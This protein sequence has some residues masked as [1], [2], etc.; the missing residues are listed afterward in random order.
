MKNIILIG[1]MGV[2]KTEVGK[3]LAKELNMTYVDTD[4]M[5]EKEQGRSINDIF[6]DDDG[7]NAFRNMETAVLKG[8][9]GKT[10]FVVSTGGGIV[11]RQENVKMLKSM[12][13]LVLLSAEPDVIYGR[14]KLESHRPLLKGSDPKSK[15]AAML[16]ARIS[17]YEKAA[18]LKV[19]TSSLSPSEACNTIIAYLR[20]AK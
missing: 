17:L 2:G 19:D 3:L 12:G 14:I 20:K 13:P 9:E 6:S 1:F 10:G 5:I 18:D 8:L 11:L 7:E 4:S 15:I 16:K